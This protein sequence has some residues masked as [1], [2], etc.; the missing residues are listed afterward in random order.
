MSLFYVDY[1]ILHAGILADD[2]QTKAALDLVRE[3]ILPD[4]K[5]IGYNLRMAT[6]N[7]LTQRL[8]GPTG[9]SR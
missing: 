3:V 5:A 6:V 8:E 1:Q 2:G 4:I 7:E 9:G